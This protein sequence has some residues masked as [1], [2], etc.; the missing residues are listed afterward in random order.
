MSNLDLDERAAGMLR[1][2]G[3]VRRR[4]VPRVSEW[5][6]PLDPVRVP[7]PLGDEVA[8]WRLGEGPAV[9]LV[10]GW[11]DDSS[12][13]TPLIGVLHAM[14]RAVVAFD[15][16]GHGQ[17]SGEGCSQ[18]RVAAAILTVCAGLGPIE[19]VCTHS[20]GGAGLATA[21]AQGLA[22]ER[23]ALVAPP[24]EQSGQFRRQALKHGVPQELV[25]AAIRLRSDWFDLSALAPSLRV[26]ALFVHSQDDPQCPHDEARRC[27]GLWPGARFHSVDGLGHRLVAQDDEV[28]P[29]LAAWL[30]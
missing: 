7:T 14:G 11:E 24:I 3:Q 21:L 20:F 12:L 27:A 28:L 17:S 8:A 10:H 13:W 16:P 15:L 5:F 23:V 9:L 22:V 1:Q 19:A 6:A 4:A 2:V 26:P 25:E 29:V 30:G 18:E